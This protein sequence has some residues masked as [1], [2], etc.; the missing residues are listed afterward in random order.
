MPSLDNEKI[1]TLPAKRKI[2]LTQELF[3]SILEIDWK[4]DWTWI[5]DPA[6]KNNKDLNKACII[7]I[8][9]S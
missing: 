3:P 4:F 1:R 5:R 7:I 9:Q 8:H 2:I 6:N